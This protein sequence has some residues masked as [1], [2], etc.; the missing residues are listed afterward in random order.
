[1]LITKTELTVL[2]LNVGEKRNES[3]YKYNL[4][5]ELVDVGLIASI[6]IR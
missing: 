4:E 1:M 6:A 5:A 2:W 3:G